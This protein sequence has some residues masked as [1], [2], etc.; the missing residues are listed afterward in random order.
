MIL[1]FV[2]CHNER[3]W[4]SFKLACITLIYKIFDPTYIRN[5]QPISLLNVDYKIVSKVY[6]NRISAVLSELLGP[7][8][9]VFKGRNVSDGLY[10]FERCY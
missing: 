8:Q 6:A 2:S 9:Y 1:N 7:M 5:Y 3:E 4:K 10:F